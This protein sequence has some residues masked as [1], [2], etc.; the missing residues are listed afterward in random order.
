MALGLIYF[1]VTIV[2]VLMLLAV[3]YF[4]YSTKNEDP[5]NKDHL[6]LFGTQYTKGHSEFIIEEKTYSE[7]RVRLVLRPRDINLIKL[8]KEKEKVG[9]FIK[10]LDKNQ[11]HNTGL[12]SHINIYFGFPQRIED[13]PKSFREST[14]GKGIAWAINQGNM[15]KHE[16]EIL[17]ERI[18]FSEEIGLEFAKSELSSAKESHL[19]DSLKEALLINKSREEKVEKKWT[20]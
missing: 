1:L 8:D 15:D 19:K 17:R 9:T 10:H 5:E 3:G 12:S 2:V 16:G 6:I 20:K 4:F 7:K 14:V 18:T 11:F 13:M